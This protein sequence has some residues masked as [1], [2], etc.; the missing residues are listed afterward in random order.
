MSTAR[1]PSGKLA[2]DRTVVTKPSA[3]DPR[4][5]AMLLCYRLGFEL[6]RSDLV[7]MAA[8]TALVVLTVFSF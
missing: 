4:G 2:E 5:W 1:R 3:L 7:I 6:R 8:G